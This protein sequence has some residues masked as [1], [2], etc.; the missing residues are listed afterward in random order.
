MVFVQM[1]TKKKQTDFR[2][3]HIQETA[4]KVHVVFVYFLER[5]FN[6]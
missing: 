2:Y 3:N 4:K 5:V 6:S 1:L